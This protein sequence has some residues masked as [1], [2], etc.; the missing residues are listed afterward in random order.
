MA[1]TEAVGKP[2]AFADGMRNEPE[3]GVL[4]WGVIVVVTCLILYLFE[5]V[6]WLVVPGLLALVG[7]Y[8]LQPLV[9]AL[10]RA[11]LKHRTAGKVVTGV[12]FLVTCVG[13]FL[14]LSLATTRGAAWKTTATHYVQG[15]LNFVGR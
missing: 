1:F 5:R 12:L 8:C 14:L 13:V 3:L 6:L 11:G 4:T 9:Q 2:A 15:G 7:Y 10:V